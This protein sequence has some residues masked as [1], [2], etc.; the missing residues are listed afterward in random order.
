MAITCGPKRQVIR[1]KM[2]R[3]NKTKYAENTAGLKIWAWSPNVEG[4]KQ[5]LDC[6]LFYSY[7]SQTDAIGELDHHIFISKMSYTVL[8]RLKDR[9]V[10][11][12]YL[13]C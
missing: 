6:V 13:K 8:C 10:W 5:H 12:S 9:I 2:I 7:F 3:N 11:F 4:V 1:K